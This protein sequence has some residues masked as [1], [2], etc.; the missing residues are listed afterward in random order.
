MLQSYA[1]EAELL[2]ASNR[3]YAS[4][5]LCLN[6]ILRKTCFIQ[7]TN[8]EP[9]TFAEKRVASRADTLLAIHFMASE[10]KTYGG[11]HFFLICSRGK[12]N[13]QHASRSQYLGLLTQNASI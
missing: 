7:A 6:L 2:M 13:N 11:K 4:S 12:D 10:K 5:S 1:D 9:A 3:V 8:I